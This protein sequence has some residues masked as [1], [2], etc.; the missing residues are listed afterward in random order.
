MKESKEQNKQLSTKMRLFYY[1][2]NH[3]RI[4]VKL[5]ATIAQMSQNFSQESSIQITFKKRNSYSFI[6]F[7]L[8]SAHTI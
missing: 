3:Q 2:N 5:Y 8:F 7:K 1:N 4:H 6:C